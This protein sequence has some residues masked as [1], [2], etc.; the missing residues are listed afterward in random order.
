MASQTLEGTFHPAALAMGLT[1]DSSNTFASLYPIV[2]S[3]NL[4][5]GMNNPSGFA[6]LVEGWLRARGF[7]YWKNKYGDCPS[8]SPIPGVNAVG[9]AA[10]VGVNAGGLAASAIGIAGAGLAGVTLG[11]SALAATISQILQHH[12]QA[13]IDEQTTLCAV[14]GYFNKGITLIDS[15]VKYGQIDAADGVS[16]MKTLV[17]QTVSGMQGI[18]KTCN[19]A[20]IYIGALKSHADFAANYYPA[21]STISIP[22]LAPG[23]SP[24]AFGSLP[25]GVPVQ[26]NQIP[27]QPPVR[28]VAPYPNTIPLINYNDQNSVTGASQ[29]SSGIT[30]K[31]PEVA[32]SGITANPSVTAQM[33]PTTNWTVVI[34][35]AA[36]ILV[37]FLAF[38]G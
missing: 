7:L 12:A 34:A 5:A 23:G 37:L 10:N 6:V 22:T 15:A 25:G 16:A 27:P 17:N 8:P 13:V 38:G 32:P 9:L 2:A 3:R 14:A 29:Q 31:I 33:S 20:C 30:G 28:S 18:L 35:I 21:I 26:A 1:W 11:I 36:G 24:T 4:P 19:A